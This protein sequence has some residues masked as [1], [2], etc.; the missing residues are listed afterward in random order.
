M[1]WMHILQT[2]SALAGIAM[3]L[4]GSACLK[5]FLWAQIR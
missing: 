5:Q 3:I 2:L 4:Y 1:N